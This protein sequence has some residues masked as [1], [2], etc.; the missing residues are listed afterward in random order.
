MWQWKISLISPSICPVQWQQ[1]YRRK[2]WIFKLITDVFNKISNKGG[3]YITAISTEESGGK[4]L[5]VHTI[6]V[7][8]DTTTVT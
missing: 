3:L 7:T 2:K 4:K 8:D 5:S 6:Y 1:E